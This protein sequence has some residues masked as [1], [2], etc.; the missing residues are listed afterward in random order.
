MFG[1]NRHARRAVNTGMNWLA[2][3]AAAWKNSSFKRALAT[4]AADMAPL[5][6]V[7]VAAATKTLFI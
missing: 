5:A 2:H 7:A 4:L 6:A 3:N 1:K